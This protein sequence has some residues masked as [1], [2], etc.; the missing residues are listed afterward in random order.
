[1]NLGPDIIKVI[2]CDV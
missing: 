1:M 2:Y